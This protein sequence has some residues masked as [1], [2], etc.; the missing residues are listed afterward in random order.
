ANVNVVGSNPITRFLQPFYNTHKKCKAV[1]TLQCVTLQFSLLVA[2]AGS[3]QLC[4][5]GGGIA[6]LSRCGVIFSGCNIHT[7]DPEHHCSRFIFGVP[8]AL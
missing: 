4:R 2:L 7:V 5:K 1:R 3:A 8:Y 6:C